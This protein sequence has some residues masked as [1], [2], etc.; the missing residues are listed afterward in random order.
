MRPL[1][2]SVLNLMRK[3]VILPF[4]LSDVMLPLC[5]HSLFNMSTTRFPLHSL[6]RM[7]RINNVKHFHVNLLVYMYF[8]NSFQ[9]PK[10]KYHSSSIT[11]QEEVK[12]RKTQLSVNTW[13]LQRP[14]NKCIIEPQLF[15]PS[16]RS[17]SSRLKISDDL[18]Q[19]GLWM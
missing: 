9:H 7:V 18:F 16:L 2:S 12:W 11:I 17:P 19:A 14:S 13:N 3:H 6:K 1:V 10:L 8:S 5:V 4:G 15:S